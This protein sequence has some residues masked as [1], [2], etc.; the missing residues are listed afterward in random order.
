MNR[1]AITSPAFT[2]PMGRFPRPG[3]SKRRTTIKNAIGL[4]G[5]VLFLM[6]PG[7]L[8]AQHVFI[9][10]VDR[11]S[12][13]QFATRPL[14][15]DLQMT[16]FPRN[17]TIIVACN[18]L[19]WEQLQRRAEAKATHTAFTNLQR[20]ITILNGEIYRNSLPLAGTAHRTPRLVLLHERGHIVCGCEDEWNADRAVG[21]E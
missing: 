11:P 9:A 18:Q 17:W 16:E 1:T 21:I 14:L 12:K 13:C 19:V 15:D 4:V 10:G 5:I 7:P 6:S 20:R 3:P 2:P 8:S